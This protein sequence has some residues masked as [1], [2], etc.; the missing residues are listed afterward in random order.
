M[1]DM[2]G[3]TVLIAFQCCIYL[4][5]CVPKVTLASNS[6]IDAENVASQLTSPVNYTRLIKFAIIL[7]FNDS[8]LFSM[9]KVSPAVNYALER[10][11]E[12]GILSRDVKFL[13]SYSDS[14]C[15]PKAAPVASF[16]F[17]M[18]QNVDVFL[19]PVCDYSLAPVAR[20]APYWN[21]PVISPGGFAHDF[22]ANKSK[23]DPEFPSLT[24]TGVTFNSLA[25]GIIKTIIHYNWTKLL[26]IYDGDGMKEI[27][28]RFCYL[29]GSA[30]IYYVKTF[31]DSSTHKFEHD[32]FLM[33]HDTDIGRM[34]QE[35]VSTEFS[36]KLVYHV[37][38]VIF[39]VKAT[40]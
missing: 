25:D 10:V 9:R 35:K 31:D 38:P 13:V 32:Q 27:M 34:L 39:V 5:L 37:I 21:L 1:S 20:Y 30:F 19:G 26:L 12:Q 23:G 11:H 16:K 36:G 6:I 29:C 28:P 33:L 22:G 18:D 24:R 17:I 40:C 3:I 7:P 4:F 15:N 2:V 14:H 8:R